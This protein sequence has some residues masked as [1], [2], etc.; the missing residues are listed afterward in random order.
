MSRMDETGQ[1]DSNTDLIFSSHNVFNLTDYKQE[2]VTWGSDHYPIEF[3]ISL[4]R[5]IY[6]KKTNRISTKKPTGRN[7]HRYFN[8]QRRK[9]QK[10]KFPGLIGR[11]KI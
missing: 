7:I 4:N 9:H 11:R 3:Q 6:K 5:K 2:E 8:G 1:R 10:S